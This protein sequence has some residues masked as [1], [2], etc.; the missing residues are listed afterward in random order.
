MSKFYN[1]TDAS[2]SL[3]SNK[4]AEMVEAGTITWSMYSIFVALVS[5]A[6]R[7]RKMTAQQFA[8][9]VGIDLAMLAYALGGLSAAG[10]MTTELAAVVTDWDD[11]CGPAGVE[12]KER[13][14]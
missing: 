4:V 9:Y 11:F 6:N 13:M 5:F 3:I 2:Y 14:A 12:M 1:L 8:D 7:G 10:L